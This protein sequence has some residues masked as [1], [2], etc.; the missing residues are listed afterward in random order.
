MSVKITKGYCIAYERKDGTIGFL[1]TDH[2]S[3]YPYFTNAKFSKRFCQRINFFKSQ[4]LFTRQKGH[5]F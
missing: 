1:G 3:G 5:L 4:N 2:Q